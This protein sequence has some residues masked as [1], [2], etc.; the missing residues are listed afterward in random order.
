MVRI[1]SGVFIVMLAVNVSVLGAAEKK[2]SAKNADKK[3]AAKTEK[4]KVNKALADSISQ[5][6]SALDSG[7]ADI[8]TYITLAGLHARMGN[9]DRSITVYEQACAMEPKNSAVLYPL[10]KAYEKAGNINAVKETY[11]AII[12]SDSNALD[13]Y[14]GLAA[15]YK[16]QKEMEQAMPFYRTYLEKGGKDTAIAQLVVSS[17]H[18]MKEFEKVIFYSSKAP[19]A[20]GALEYQLMLADAYYATKNYVKAL[21]IF[22]SALDKKP[23]PDVKSVLLKK[24]GLAYFYTND[25]AK[26]ISYFDQF[27]KA[28]KIADSDISYFMAFFQENS[29]K[30]LAMKLYE[31]NV[32]QFPKDYRNFLRLGGILAKNPKT[33]ARALPML[34]TAAKLADTVSGAWLEIAKAYR[35]QKNLDEELKAYKKYKTLAP[36]DYTAD[37]RIGAIMVE[38]KE[39][40]EAQRILESVKDKASGSLEFVKAL[41]E[42]YTKKEMFK[43]A[44]L[45]LEQAR[46]KKVEDVSTQKML[47]AAYVRTEMND[48]AAKMLKVILEKDRN[49]DLLLQYAQLLFKA[50]KVGAA[51]SAVQEILATAEPSVPVLML[52]GSIQKANKKYDDALATYKEVTGLEPKNAVAIYESAEIYMTLQKIQWADKFYNRALNA[53]PNYALAYLGLA[54]IAAIRKD[55]AKYRELLEKARQLDPNN[56]KIKDELAGTAKKPK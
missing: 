50:G 9:S 47:C 15:F 42:V 41:G 52:M 27:T 43:E 20:L 40:D 53:D 5:L 7:K 39:I 38:K 2:G 32:K 37:A 30:D 49:P 54:K 1:I 12:A 8:N 44:I 45:L 17:L 33:V 21:D 46:G 22:K 6:Q 26:A 31:K 19:D 34:Q 29:K 51:D 25:T 14:K 3:A 11:S 24:T 4:P 10:A 23:S 36:D 13:A 18:K 28:S 16:A 48:K 55:N 56:P 35:L